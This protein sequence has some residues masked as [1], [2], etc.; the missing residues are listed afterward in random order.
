LAEEN[1]I[2]AEEN[3]ITK[4]PPGERRDDRTPRNEAI[5][6]PRLSTGRDSLAVV[7]VMICVAAIAAGGILLAFGPRSDEMGWFRT[8]LTR[9][10]QRA[11][12]KVTQFFVAITTNREGGGDGHLGRGRTLVQQGAYDAGLRE[13]EQAVTAAPDRYEVHFWRGRALVKTGREDDAI[14]AFETAIELNPDYSYAYD[15]LGW[16]YFHRQ[17]YQTSLTYLNRSLSLRPDNGWV[18]YQRGRIYFAL[19]EQGKAFQDA[20]A[21]C[22]LDF[23]LACQVLKRYGRES[24]F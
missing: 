3:N 7:F 21:A 8:D 13:L 6:Q 19:G 4:D 22:R 9:I 17:E 11:E 23:Q 16:I 14:A 1:N 24:D 18:Y 2:A 15:N 20:E 10:V 12:E 5:F